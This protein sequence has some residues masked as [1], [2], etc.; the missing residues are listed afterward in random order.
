M[1]GILNN[2]IRQAR[3]QIVEAVFDQF[4]SDFLGQLVQPEVRPS[5]PEVTINVL[6]ANVSNKAKLSMLKH[7]RIGRAGIDTQ[8]LAIYDYGCDLGLE[9]EMDC[10]DIVKL[11]QMERQRIF[12]ER[13]YRRGSNIFDSDDDHDDDNEY[14]V[15]TDD[16]DDDDDVEELS[17]DMEELRELITLAFQDP[18]RFIEMVRSGELDPDLAAQTMGLL[19]Q[20]V[21]DGEE[22]D[23]SD[24]D[25]EDQWETDDDDD[26]DD[27]NDN[28]HE[29]EDVGDSDDD[30]WEDMDSN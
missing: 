16:D 3:N 5:Q 4:W 15:E 22:G 23:D 17:I 19:R 8:P 24:E 28:D 2:H 6:N 29:S 21:D 12:D 20:M 10:W 9:E 14:G 18:N 13:K 25:D 27:D 30:G 26:N 1:K 7:P 11:K